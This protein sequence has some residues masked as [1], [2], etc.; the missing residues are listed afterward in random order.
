MGVADKE[1]GHGFACLIDG[2]AHQAP[3]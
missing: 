2:V 1:V 3:L